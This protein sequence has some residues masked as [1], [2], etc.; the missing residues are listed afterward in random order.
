MI[1]SGKKLLLQKYIEKCDESKQNG[2]L[3]AWFILFD[4]FVLN[5]NYV[6]IEWTETRSLSNFLQPKALGQKDTIK[7]TYIF[8]GWSSTLV[9]KKL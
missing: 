7:S 8:E 6:F 5:N 9:V 1:I 3:K 2:C 4:F